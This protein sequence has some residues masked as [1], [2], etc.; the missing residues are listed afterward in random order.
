MEKQNSKNKNTQVKKAKRL[1]TNLQY[2][3]FE[4][5]RIY[6]NYNLT[7]LSKLEN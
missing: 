5:K 3:S 4:N 2:S 1:N 7:L 6:L